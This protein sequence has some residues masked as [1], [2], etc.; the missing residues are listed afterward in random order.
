M[1]RQQRESLVE[2]LMVW[3]FVLSLAGLLGLGC[4]EACKILSVIPAAFESSPPS[5]RNPMWASDDDARPSQFGR[6][7]MTPR[8]RAQD[9]DRAAQQER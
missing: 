3:G 7:R 5:F 4:F 6:G 2:T 8:E 9:R 1:Q